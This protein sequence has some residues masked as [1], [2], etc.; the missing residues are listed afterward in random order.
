MTP[1]DLSQV[2]DALVA[3]GITGPHQSHSRRNNI[4]KI[5]AMLEGDND[6][7]FG[8]S[9]LGKY[10]ATE[11]LGFLAELTGCSDD[12]EDECEFDTL[13]PQRTVAGIVAAA[14]RL[15]DEAARGSSLLVATGHPTGMLEHH[16]RVVDAY[17][18]AGGKI[19]L[20]REDENLT[21][22]SGRH[23]EV[24]YTGGV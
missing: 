9:G 23:A 13:D 2:A 18:R 24:R 11:V 7:S 10:S 4:S 19:T 21:R 5:N 14:R 8:I 1:P 3:A 12:I 16:I 17:R 22:R 20:L 15:K 6:G